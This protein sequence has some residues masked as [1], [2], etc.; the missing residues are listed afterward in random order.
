MTGDITL[1]KLDGPG[2]LQM[3]FYW[4]ARHITLMKSGGPGGL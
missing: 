2:G 4:D 3:L 1:M